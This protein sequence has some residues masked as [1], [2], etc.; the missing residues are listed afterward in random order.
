MS[1]LV[2]IATVADAS[3][4]KQVNAS[5]KA[6]LRAHYHHRPGLSLPDRD[7]PA[8]ILIVACV[9]GMVVGCCEYFVRGKALEFMSLGVLSEYRNRGVFR[10]I[11]R[12]LEERAVEKNLLAIRCRTIEN[13]GN[14]TIFKQIGMQITG[15]ESS[16][17]YVL[18]SL[19][20]ALEIKFEKMLY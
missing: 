16:K 4:L 15:V 1:I 6:M 12:Y 18:P 13:T 8:T 3:A 9:H 5:A 17:I 11:F 14:A 20:P 10:E 7:M 19:A 2:R